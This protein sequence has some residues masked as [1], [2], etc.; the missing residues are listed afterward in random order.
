MTILIILLTKVNWVRKT[1]SQ[2]KGKKWIYYCTS[3]IVLAS[4]WMRRARW[5]WYFKIYICQ[6]ASSESNLNSFTLTMRQLE[7]SVAC[8]NTMCDQQ[9][10]PKPLPKQVSFWHP[11]NCVILEASTIKNVEKSW[12]SQKKCLKQCRC[13][14]GQNSILTKVD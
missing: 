1:V 9:R 3:N 6:A 11:A 4:V 14:S 7:W 5:C 12:T 10:Y 13:G 8:A 2:C